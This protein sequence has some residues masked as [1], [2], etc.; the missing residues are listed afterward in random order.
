[1]GTITPID[2]NAIA[3][4]TNQV[5]VEVVDNVIEQLRTPML[6][7]ESVIESLQAV[8][9]DLNVADASPQGPKPHRKMGGCKKTPAVKQPT[10]VSYNAS[11]RDITAILEAA[12]EPMSTFK[13]VKALAEFNVR[14]TEPTLRKILDVGERNEKFHQPE[15]GKWTL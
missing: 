15:D 3:K 11:Q 12:G 8:K 9:K 4:A 7:L 14:V 10:K 5:M 2:V 6:Q 1:M 13:I